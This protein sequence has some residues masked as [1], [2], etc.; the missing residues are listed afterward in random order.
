MNSMNTK[1]AHNGKYQPKVTS[2]WYFEDRYFF[3]TK[4]LDLHKNLSRCM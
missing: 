1:V 4:T 2:E 3:F